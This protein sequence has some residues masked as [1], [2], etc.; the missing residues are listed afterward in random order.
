MIELSGTECERI[1]RKATGH[2]NVE[3]VKFNVESFAC[4]S[5]F[6]GEYF[7]LKIHAAVND[8]MCELNFFV[9][10]LPMRDLKQ[11]K[12]LIETGI[13]RK[14]VKLYENLMSELSRFAREEK[15]WCPNAFIY[16]EDLLVLDDLSL[17]GFKMLP[18]Q[19]KFSQLH[20][21]ITLK[22][23]A[24]FHCCGI[25]Y[26][27]AGKSIAREFG[28]TLF[29]TSVADIPWFHSGLRVILFVFIEEF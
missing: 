9:K 5:G 19:Y 14:E 11:R 2:K 3:I 1:V 6:L 20:V 23:L 18:F 21:E 17:K 8:S 13:F 24:S 12:M 15:F 25:M 7:R 28:Q 27:G 10:S 26:E 4:Y 16:R 22:S 29:E